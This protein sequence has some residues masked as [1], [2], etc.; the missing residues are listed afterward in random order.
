[1]K[2]A[3]ALG[4]PFIEGKSHE[5]RLEDQ[6]FTNVT[7]KTF[8]WPTN[9]WPK[10]PRYKEIGLW[11][12]ANIEGNLETISSFLLKQGLG[13]SKEE[14]IVFISQVRAEMRNTKVHAYWE[15]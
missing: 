9:T 11:T 4:R 15:V 7:L 6:G 13:M 8:K 1:M 14:I 3:A 5:K 2:G 12:L 10:D